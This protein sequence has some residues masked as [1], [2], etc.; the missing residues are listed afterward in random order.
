MRFITAITITATL[1][2]GLTVAQAAMPGN[3]DGLKPEAAEKMQGSNLAWFDARAIG[4]EGTTFNDME[5]SY[6]RL[7]DRA[8][9]DVPPAVWHLSRNTTGLAV[10][11]VTNSSQISAA[12][13]NGGQFSMNHM[14]PTG[15]S[16][17]DLY[18]KGEKGWKYLGTGRPVGSATSQ[19]LVSKRPD[20]SS[21]YMLYLPLYHNIT[22][23]K[24]GI[25]T[26]ATVAAAPARKEKPIV[27]YGTSMTQGGCAS[28]TGMCHVA[29]LGRWLNNEVINLGF[30]GSG[31]GEPEVAALVAEIDARAFVIES[32]PNMNTE[33]VQTR[34][35]PMVNM[36]RA[37]HPEAPILLVENPLYGREMPQNEALRT[38]FENLKKAEVKKLWL[39]PGGDYQLL[40][41]GGR[42]GD[43]ENGTVDGVH[44][45]DLGF[46]RMAEAYLPMM[47]KILSGN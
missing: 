24:I 22:S 31:K 43:K 39:L 33:Q 4:L 28:R 6:A 35:E 9:A 7:P 15:V 38:A 3:P 32:L 5:T 46:V 19:T 18:T 10:R 23:L 27:F 41:E 29:I 2:V 17:L 16:G 45:T 13:D 21:E 34:I 26:T 1:A 42:E 20:E 47:K 44:P 30:S 8:K 37:K 36:I 11:F 40:G 12:W 25:D 14:A